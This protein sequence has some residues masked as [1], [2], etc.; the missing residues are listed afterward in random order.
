[1]S[2]VIAKT[3]ISIIGCGAMGEALIAGIVAAGSVEPDSIFASDT[4]LE[5]VE[6]LGRKYGVR[7]GTDNVM[8]ADFADVVVLAVKPGLI[9]DVLM[10]IKETIITGE[11]LVISVAAGVTISQLLNGLQSP[12]T[13][14]AKI[15][16]VMPNMPVLV[17]EGMSVLVSGPGVSDHDLDIAEGIFCA[18]GKTLVVEEHMIDAVTGLSGSGPAYVLLLIEALADGGVR[19]GLPRDIALTLATQTV[20]GTAHLQY[21]TGEHPA[22]LK[23]RITS[24]GGTTSV[25][26]HVLEKGGFRG[27][28]SAAVEMATKRAAELRSK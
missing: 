18:V 19:M 11:K 23:D 14:G 28:V 3:S 20:K 7:S 1:M 8:A 6:V 5:R 21:Q 25:A 24:P 27:M 9:N 13:L 2:K 17:R 22:R 15:I 10:Q 4:L 12:E 16:R 26:V